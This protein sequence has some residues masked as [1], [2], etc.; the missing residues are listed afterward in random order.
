L[1][2]AENSSTE[3]LPSVVCLSVITKPSKEGGLDPLG[4]VE[5]WRT[6]ALWSH[7]K[8]KMW[9]SYENYIGKNIY[10]RYSGHENKK[11]VTK[12]IKKRVFDDIK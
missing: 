3:V 11:C 12:R 5:S 10:P 6:E 7:K 8:K 4:A 2:R 1:R 9:C